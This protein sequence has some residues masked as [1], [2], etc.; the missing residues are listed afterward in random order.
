MTHR[1]LLLL[2]FHISSPGN[3]TFKCICI[4]TL[5]PTLLCVASLN[6]FS[7][8]IMKEIFFKSRETTLEN[9]MFSC[10]NPPPA[11]ADDSDCICHVQIET[12]SC[13]YIYLQ[14]FYPTVKHSYIFFHTTSTGI[15]NYPEFMGTLLVDDIEVGYYDSD[16]NIKAKQEAAKK[17]LDENPELLQLY[18]KECSERSKRLKDRLSNFM[19]VFNQSGGNVCFM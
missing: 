3:I 7:F 1:F 5:F 13:F 6:T 17:M 14:L 10:L 18:T 8:I 11:A 12:G 4:Q 15:P 2:F 19:Q 16:V 9:F